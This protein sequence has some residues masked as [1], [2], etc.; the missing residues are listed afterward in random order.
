MSLP[1]GFERSWPDLAVLCCVSALGV[2]GCGGGS[3]EPPIAPPTKLSV[4]ATQLDFGT[5]ALGEIS[6][7]N[8]LSVTKFWPLPI[9]GARRRR[10]RR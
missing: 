10:D 2:A 8:H 1:I 4:D 5:L 9:K 7:P 6:A 3:I